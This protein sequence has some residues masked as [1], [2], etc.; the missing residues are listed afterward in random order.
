MSPS[1][2]LEPEVVRDLV[3]RATGRDV[4]AYKRLL[5]QFNGLVWSICHSSGLNRTEGEDVVQ[6]V[7]LRVV[8]YLPTLREPEKFAGWLAAITRHEC[9]AVLRTRS[10]FSSDPVPDDYP[11]D[12]PGPESRLIEDERR[13]SVRKA[14]ADLDTRC[15][16][17]LTLLSSTS[18]VSYADISAA[19]GMPVA[20]IGPTRARCLEKLRRAPSIMAM[21]EHA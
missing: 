11:A 21:T 18:T 10:R 13:V 16:E 20:S 6:G 14:I 5:H 4:A 1:N 15:R 7:W 17:L 8:Q 12:G 9:A 2:F 19:M 3:V